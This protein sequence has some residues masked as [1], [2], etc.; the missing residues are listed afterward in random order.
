MAGIS[1]VAGRERGPVSNQ[2]VYR[3]YLTGLA[4]LAG[5]TP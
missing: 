5:L 2:C 3:T 1:G 4:G